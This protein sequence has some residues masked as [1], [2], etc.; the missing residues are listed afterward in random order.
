MFGFL[1]PPIHFTMVN[2]V[3]WVHVKCLHDQDVEWIHYSKTP[4]PNY[5]E[6]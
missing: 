4:H 1:T 2:M 6:A 5:Y 3:Q